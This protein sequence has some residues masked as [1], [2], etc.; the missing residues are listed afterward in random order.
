LW[1][2]VFFINLL[3]RNSKRGTSDVFLPA[4][5]ALFC[6]VEASKALVFLTARR[7]I[8]PGAFIPQL[9]IASQRFAP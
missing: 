3:V 1:G 7:V 8:V 4:A 9:N 5:R 6:G 2:S